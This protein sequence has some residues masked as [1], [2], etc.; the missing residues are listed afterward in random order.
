MIPATCLVSSRLK[1]GASGPRVTVEVALPVAVVTTT[2]TVPVAVSSGACKLICPGLTNQ[3]YAALPSISTLVPP[4]HLPPQ[5]V[6]RSEHAFGEFA[7]ASILH[8]VN[9]G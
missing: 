1:D 5:D 7:V 6:H 4:K 8:A 2:G 9:R 3:R